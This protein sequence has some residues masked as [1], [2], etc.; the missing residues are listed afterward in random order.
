MAECP[1][2]FASAGVTTP[3]SEGEYERGPNYDTGWKILKT[4]L[5]QWVGHYCK[6]HAPA[7]PNPTAIRSR[8]SFC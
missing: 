1:H 2:Y 5:E 4:G 6:V 3:T 8:V 7:M